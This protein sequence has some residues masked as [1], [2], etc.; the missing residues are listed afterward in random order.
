M[1]EISLGPQPPA[2]AGEP[3]ARS[4]G[5]RA[6][7]LQQSLSPPC[8]IATVSSADAPG[9]ASRL[10]VVRSIV[11]LLRSL[12][13]SPPRPNGA[14]SC[15][16]TAVRRR[17]TSSITSQNCRSDTG[18]GPPPKGGGALPCPGRPCGQ[19]EPRP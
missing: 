5:K 1:V 18:K 2:S 12:L 13:R 3:A 16:C 6:P 19:N 9:P 10:L 14:S 15:S 17:W 11:L 4:S 8:S 7:G